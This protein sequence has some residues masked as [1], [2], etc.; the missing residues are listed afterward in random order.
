MVFKPRVEEAQRHAKT[1]MKNLQDDRGGKGAVL[2]GR[3][4]TGRP[5]AGKRRYD[6]MDA[7]EG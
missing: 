3:N 5:G 4:R 2:K 7:E 1:E 6:D